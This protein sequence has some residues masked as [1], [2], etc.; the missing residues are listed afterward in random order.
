[1]PIRVLFVELPSLLGETVRAAFDPE[2]DDVAE[3][4][5]GDEAI[6]EA[7]KLTPDIVFIDVRMPDMDGIDV[8][9]AIRGASPSAKVILFMEASGARI[10]EAIRAGVSGYLLEDASTEDLA[11]AVRLALREKTLV[12]PRLV[13]PLLE[14][15]K[16]TGEPDEGPHLSRRDRAILQE[17]SSGEPI[18]EIS[19][20]LELS[21]RTVRTQL[22]RIFQTLAVG[23]P[24]DPPRAS[25]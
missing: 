9:D 22:K 19:Q 8:I 18:E 10:S 1:M 24:P 7:W 3:A 4:D 16:A 20:Q 21:P 2:S 6:E 23:G 25:A 5:S 13:R 17:V 14:A 15:I 12:D 11:E